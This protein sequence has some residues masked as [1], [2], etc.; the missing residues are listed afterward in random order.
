M[1][2]RNL[3]KSTNLTSHCMIADNFFSRLKGLMGIDSF[4]E[5]SGL[6]ITPCNS[7]HMF[8]MKIP[9]DILFIDKN[10][11]VVHMVENLKP[12]KLTRIVWKAHSVIELP[13]GV[14]KNS[15]TQLG[16]HLDLE[17]KPVKSY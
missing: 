6:F 13:V 17:K 10:N 1:L 7:V 16:D 11:T 2:I 8:F 14:I 15:F 4:I 5:G 9:L 3:T 12:W